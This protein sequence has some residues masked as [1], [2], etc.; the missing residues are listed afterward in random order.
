MY[1][2]AET[3]TD[4]NIEKTS[5]LIKKVIDDSKIKVVFEEGTKIMVQ[6]YQL[7]EK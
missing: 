5:E 1:K 4:K 3:D 6:N 7:S 2:D